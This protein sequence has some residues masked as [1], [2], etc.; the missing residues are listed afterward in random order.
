MSK[1]ERVFSKQFL[2]AEDDPRWERWQKKRLVVRMMPL[3]GPVTVITVDAP[4][5][6][7]PEWEGWL[8]VDMA[9]H[10]YPLHRDVHAVAYE[11]VRPAVGD[12]R[13]QQ[14]RERLAAIVYEWGDVDPT[15]ESWTGGEHLV[16]LLMPVLLDALAAARQ[17]NERLRDEG[18]PD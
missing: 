8:A 4:T 5:K 14:I 2:P 9:G 12:E 17:E 16:N 1:Q 11:P 15:R 10:P 6:L 13:E 7:P 3:R 18:N